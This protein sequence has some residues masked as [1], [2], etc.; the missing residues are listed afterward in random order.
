MA[1]LTIGEVSRQAGLRPSALR[2]Y[3]DVGLLPPPT[4]VGG[5][6]R[7]D[8]TILERLAVI[9][10]AQSAGFTVAETRT[11]LHGFAPDTPP[12]DRW[13]ALAAAKLPEVEALIARARGMQEILEAGLRCECLTLV[14]CARLLGGSPTGSAR[15]GGGI[16]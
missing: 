5:Q 4:R 2:Y 9:R 8:A 16:A 15:E 1:H 14:A 11:F 3:E 12:P 10:L 6:R 13:R 7:Y